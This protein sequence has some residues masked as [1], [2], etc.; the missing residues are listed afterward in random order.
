MEEKLKIYLS[1]PIANRTDD[2]CL[3]WRLHVAK[4]WKEKYGGISFSPMRRDYRETTS[5]FDKEIVEFDK[6][7]IER[8]DA[9]VVYYD[10]PS[11]GTS[12]EIIY[13]FER[14][15][16]IAIVEKTPG[17]YMSPWMRYHSHSIFS[18]FEDALNF[19][20]QKLSTTNLKEK[21]NDK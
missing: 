11:V 10:V 19:I 16:L 18:T 15:K 13:A 9:L 6:I 17:S 14:G 2:E 4:L 1:G 12:M 21:N 8:S 20:N 5:H 7:D 3:K